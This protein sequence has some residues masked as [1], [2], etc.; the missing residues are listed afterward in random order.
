MRVKKNNTMIIN[1]L[2]PEVKEL[3]LLQAGILCLSGE[4]GFD[5]GNI[6]DTERDEFEW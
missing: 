5:P 1:Y 6:E 3:C 4:T 2:S